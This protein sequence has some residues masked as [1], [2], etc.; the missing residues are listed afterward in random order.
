ML[1]Y[2]ATQRRLLRGHSLRAKDRRQVLRSMARKLIFAPMYQ[3][4]RRKPNGRDR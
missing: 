1:I 3:P 4:T 2:S